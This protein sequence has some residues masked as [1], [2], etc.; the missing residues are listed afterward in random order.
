MDWSN[1]CN[2]KSLSLAVSVGEGP[3]RHHRN[4][5]RCLWLSV[6][7]QPLQMCPLLFFGCLWLL[8]CQ[9]HHQLLLL[10]KCSPTAEIGLGSEPL[11]RLVELSLSPIHV[12]QNSLQPTGSGYPSWHWF[13]S[14]FALYLSLIL[15]VQKVC[16]SEVKWAF[17]FWPS[18]V[19]DSLCQNPDETLGFPGCLPHF[20]H[21]VPLPFPELCCFVPGSEA[22]VCKAQRGSLSLLGRRICSRLCLCCAWWREW[23]NC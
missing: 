18:T 9:A 21:N 16:I 22:C 8:V 7:H 10:V 13:S 6:S 5:P 17:S 12:I 14:P 3:V 1:P 11:G 15:S 20:W 23:V 4:L 2:N 19:H